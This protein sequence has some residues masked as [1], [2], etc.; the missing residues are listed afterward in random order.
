M[1]PTF[2]MLALLGL[3]LVA[4]SAACAQE[5]TVLAIFPAERRAEMTAALRLELAGR[6]TLVEDSAIDASAE[7]TELRAIAEARGATHVVWVVFPTGLLGPAEVRVLDVSRSAPAHATTPEAWDVVD[8]RVVAV[9]AS[10]VMDPARI[11]PAVVEPAPPAVVE[12]RVVVSTTAASAAPVVVPPTESEAVEP[13]DPRAARRFS[14]VVGPSFTHLT[15]DGASALGLTYDFAFYARLTE[16]ASLGTRLRIGQGSFTNAE[17]TRVHAGLGVPSLLVSFR[18]PIGTSA[19]IEL[20]VH[21]EGGLFFYGH[22]ANRWSFG[23]GA[24]ATMTLELGSG[25]GIQLDYTV[26]FFGFETSE[27]LGWGALT[28]A[29]VGRFD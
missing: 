19:M 27:L 9:L 25:Q 16:W 5:A 26:D 29:Y 7:T 8:A 24:G 11:E 18:E 14:I 22:D 15:S 13:R 23:F 20:G 2:A 4:P 10:S 6:A 12:T 1:Q 17:A 21:A 28:L 3:A